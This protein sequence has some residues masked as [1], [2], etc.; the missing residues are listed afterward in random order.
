MATARIISRREWLGIAVGT[1]ATLA[2]SPALL[3]ALRQPEGKLIQ[4]AIPSSGELLPVIG[5][6]RGGVQNN[7]RLKHLVKMLDPSSEAYAMLR[8]VV[9]TMVDNGGTVL[10][11]VGGS[12]GQQVTGMIA[13]E[14][15][16]Q[17]KIFWSTGLD[18]RGAVR[19]AA[20]VKEHLEAAF[21]KLKVPKIDLMMLS[22]RDVPTCLGVVKEAKKEGRIRY[23]GVQTLLPPPNVPLDP[24]RAELEAIM[25]SE[26]IDFIGVT[27][28]H[29]A[30]RRVEETILPLAQE[31]KIGVA[32]YM[33]FGLGRLFK[34]VDT[35]PLPE[36]AADFDAKTWAQFFLKYVVSHPAV[37]V[38]LPGTSSAKHM[39][40]N[41]G[42]G[43]GRLPDEATRKK[44]AEFMDALPAE[45]A[46]GA[47]Q[48]KAPEAPGRFIRGG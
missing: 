20:A 31:R 24:P 3:A 48:P 7:P 23:I 8:A 25:R 38:V 17:N 28:Y 47:A 33:P 39:L 22:A 41:I 26:P 35:T 12:E 44:M 34:R 13:S 14:L 6:A 4:R 10:D 30:N 27:H 21:A 43:S 1:G 19:D 37:T 11:S 32:A 29:L 15:G 40:D 9:K 46:P 18:I 2:L 42:G 5:V 45:P 36:W 16:I